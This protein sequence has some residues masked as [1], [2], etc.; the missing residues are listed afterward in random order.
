MAIVLRAPPLGTMAIAFGPCRSSA[1]PHHDERRDPK[2]RPSR[3]R[4]GGSVEMPITMST[5]IVVAMAI[6]QSG[7]ESLIKPSR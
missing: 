3:S 6:I 7:H 2:Q 1:M 5:V 4:A